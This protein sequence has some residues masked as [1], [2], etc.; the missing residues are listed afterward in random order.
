MPIPLSD[1][2]PVSGPSRPIFQTL[3]REARAVPWAAVAKGVVSRT[4]P[5]VKASVLITWR[6][7]VHSLGRP[8]A[9]C[10]GAGLTACEGETDPVIALGLLGKPGLGTSPAL[11][12]RVPV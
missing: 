6:M 8:A 5:K 11:S 4:T 3:G 7:K 9:A 12:T 10:L 1:W 2:L